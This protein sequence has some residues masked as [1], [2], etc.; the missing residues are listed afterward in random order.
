M[1]CYSEARGNISV[2]FVSFEAGPHNAAQPGLE[3]TALLLQDS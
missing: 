1:G 2:V 3:L